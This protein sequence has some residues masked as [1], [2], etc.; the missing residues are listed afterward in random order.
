MVEPLSVAEV[1]Y[2]A[3]KQITAETES[4]IFE[5]EESD[6]YSTSIWAINLLTKTDILDA[7]FPSDEAIMEVMNLTEKP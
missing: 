4:Q 2:K 3:I 1:T 6:L 7:A 5:P